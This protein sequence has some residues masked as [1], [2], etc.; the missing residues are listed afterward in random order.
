[1]YICFSN[2]ATASGLFV[3]MSFVIEKVKLEQHCDPCLAV[4]VIRR[5]RKQFI[6]D[7]VR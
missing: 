2:G 3:A 6:T 5:N 4:R 7:K 1:M